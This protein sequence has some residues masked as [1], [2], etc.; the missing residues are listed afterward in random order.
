MTEEIKI[1]LEKIALRLGPQP[2]VAQ[3]EKT[4]SFQEAEQLMGLQILDLL[5][6][7]R[8]IKIMRG[9]EGPYYEPLWANNGRVYIRLSHENELIDVFLT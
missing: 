7:R 3:L 9:E 6:F 5:N 8:K 4:I 2:A 1:L